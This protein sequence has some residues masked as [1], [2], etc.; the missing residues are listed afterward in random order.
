MYESTYKICCFSVFS[1]H[2]SISFSFFLHGESTVCASI[3]VREHPPLWRLHPYHL[4][5]VIQCSQQALPGASRLLIKLNLFEILFCLRYYVTSFCMVSNS[6][7]C[8]FKKYISRQRF[9]DALIISICTFN[10]NFLTWFICS[11]C[12]QKILLFKVVL[13]PYGLA[14]T[15]TGQSYKESDSNTQKVL[16]EWKQ[17]FVVPDPETWELPAEHST[18]PKLVEVVVGECFNFGIIDE[19]RS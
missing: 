15:L 1:T 3:D 16:E 18:L 6:S 10:C 14:G 5:A 17:F 11:Y 7:S 12:K 13:A 8:L 2:L 9:Y 4:N 19:L